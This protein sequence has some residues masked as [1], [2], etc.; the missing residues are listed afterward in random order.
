M[1]AMSLIDIEHK[2]PAYIVRLRAEGAFTHTLL[3]E[4]EAALDRVASSDGPACIVFTGEG[5]SFSTGFD[6]DAFFGV[7]TAERER[8]LAAGVKLLGRMLA[9]PVPTAA[10][11]NGHAFGMGAML[12]L[13]CDYRTM[14]ADR[15]FF[16]FPE[17]DL[18][19]T[20][21]EGML[22]LLRLKLDWKVLRDLILTGKRIDGEEAQRLGIIDEACAAEEVLPR[23]VALVTLLAA[24]DRAAFAALKRGMN[25][26]A[27]ESI[28]GKQYNTGS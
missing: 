8:L 1:T 15:G 12:A 17:I 24:K 13:A 10:A 7:S 11:I 25:Q 28:R 3:A 2:P 20:I 23:A 21:P 14:R 18:K 22:A 9:L 26:E 4:L 6:L 16:C 27:I 19:V 5:K